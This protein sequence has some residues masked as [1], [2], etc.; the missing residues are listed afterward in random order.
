MCSPCVYYAAGKTGL[1][2]GLYK[3]TDAGWHKPLYIEQWAGP[4]PLNYA[5]TGAEALFGKFINKA[6]WSELELGLM[7]V[8]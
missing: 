2:E 8:N 5:L 4:Y 6:T 7:V 1:Q 3:E